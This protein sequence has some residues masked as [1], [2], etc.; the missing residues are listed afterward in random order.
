MRNFPITRKGLEKLEQEL[1]KLKFQ[2]R[3]DVIKA[4]AVA[5]DQGDL[6]ENAEYHAAREKQ[7]FIEGRIIDLEDKVSRAEI[8]TTPIDQDKVLFGATVYLL[9]QD[10]DKHITYTVVGEYES[11][12]SKGMISIISPLGRALISKKVGDIIEV[13][14]P[15]NILNYEIL[16][17]EYK[18]VEI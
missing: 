4:I 11:D 17:V 13:V 7:G 18:D 10:N 9:D 6:S 1:K 8:I 2:D 14:T 5:R 15:K 12:I 3:P 16:K